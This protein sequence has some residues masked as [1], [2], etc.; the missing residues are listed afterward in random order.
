MSTKL[1]ELIEK[2]DLLLSERESEL[3]KKVNRTYKKAIQAAE[4]EFRAL[5]KLPPELKDVRRKE[6]QDI[7]DKTVDAFEREYKTLIEPIRQAMEEFFDEGLKES[8]QVLQMLEEQ[9]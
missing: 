1:R 8:G 4:L 3:I 7:L 2:N 9:K 5:E 6:V